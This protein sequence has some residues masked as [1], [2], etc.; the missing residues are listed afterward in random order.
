MRAVA[1]LI[2]D[3]F[4]VRAIDAARAAKDEPVNIFPLEKQPLGF[5]TVSHFVTWP[6]SKYS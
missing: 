6:G 3:K 4:S 1:T 2:T 5:D